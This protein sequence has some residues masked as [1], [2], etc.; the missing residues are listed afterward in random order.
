MSPKKHTDDSVTHMGSLIRGLLYGLAFFLPGIIVL[1][2]WDT[3]RLIYN[4]MS[5]MPVIAK[6][7]RDF[8]TGFTVAGELFLDQS[9]R[10][11]SVENHLIRGGNLVEERD[12]ESGPFAWKR[13]EIEE[14]LGK[15][16]GK[17]KIRRSRNYLDYI[18]QYRPTAV[19]EMY[20]TRIP[21]SVTLAQ[22]LLESKA[23]K[24]HLATVAKNH[25][26]IK[27]RKRKGYK[28]DGV[29][30]DNDFYHHRLAYGC[31][32]RS[33]DH[34]WDRFEM[35]ETVDL[36]YQHHSL[37]LT[38]S[39]RY[40][41]MIDRYHTGEN[42]A[43]EKKWFGL[44]EVPYYAAW[45]AGLKKSGYATSKTYAQKLAYIIET[46]ELWRVDYNAVLAL[47]GN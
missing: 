21:A 20:R 43:I 35:Y 12:F 24:S 6:L 38:E 36:S 45:S 33:D 1:K 30:D 29:I 9:F 22:G 5:D 10:F 7:A 3:I 41:W 8:E 39:S 44:E 37:L 15:E 47:P 26:G 17:K 32:Q 25:F 18:E 19:R 46:Y 40:N 28:R 14:K 34:D 13:S 16:F 23:G 4:G 27:C 42:Y 31:E 2:H 11:Y